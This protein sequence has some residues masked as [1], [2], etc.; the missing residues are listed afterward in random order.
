LLCGGSAVEPLSACW[1]DA[2]EQKGILLRGIG[3][4]VVVDP[5]VWTGRVSQE[6]LG[7]TRLVLR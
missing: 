2:L 3:T 5:N 6:G 1:I 7:M 4:L